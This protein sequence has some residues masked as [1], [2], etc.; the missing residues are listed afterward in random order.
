MPA[1]LIV[2]N[3]YPERDC[4]AASTLL[5]KVGTLTVLPHRPCTWSNL[6]FHF[7]RFGPISSSAS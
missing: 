6:A 7:R 1:L 5:A 3:L 4:C 2:S